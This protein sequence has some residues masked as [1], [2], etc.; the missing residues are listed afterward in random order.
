[1]TACCLEIMWLR[2]LLADIGHPQTKPTTVFCD[3]T[4]A[5]SVAKSLTVSA[6][7]RHFSW[8]QHKIRELV[9]NKTVHP[10]YVHT[11]ANT[12][13]AFTKGL[14]K[15][16][17]RAFMRAVLQQDHSVQHCNHVLI[18]HLSP[19]LCSAYPLF[20]LFIN[21]TIS[22]LLNFVLMHV[23]LLFF[24]FDYSSMGGI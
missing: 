12:A 8:R 7:T 16:A 6:R 23:F 14:N 5:I 21:D 2:N 4:A 22:S 17:F 24:F 10:L 19:R 18:L 15:T 9:A 20:S 1:M 3:N 13:D 11:T